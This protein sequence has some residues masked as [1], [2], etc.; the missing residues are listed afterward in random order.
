MNKKFLTIILIFCFTF[1]FLYANTPNAI[2]S[3]NN[4]YGG[5]DYIEKNNNES[6]DEKWG[7]NFVYNRIGVKEKDKGTFFEIITPVENMFKFVMAEIM[8]LFPTTGFVFKQDYN[9]YTDPMDVENYN[10]SH[11]N[12]FLYSSNEYEKY[13]DVN[14]TNH[15]AVIGFKVLL[16]LVFLAVCFYCAFCYIRGLINSK[17]G[18]QVSMLPVI[19]IRVLVCIFAFLLLPFLPP[20]LLKAS[21]YLGFLI[22]GI[23]F[24]ERMLFEICINWAGFSAIIVFLV[25]IGAGSIV[26][27]NVGGIGFLFTSLGN[28]A[29]P[30]FACFGTTFILGLTQLINIYVWEIELFIANV[31]LIF[32]LPFTLFNL[33]KNH[34]SFLGIKISSIVKFFIFNFIEICVAVVV[35]SLLYKLTKNGWNYEF[36]QNFILSLF[37]YLIPCLMLSTLMPVI[38]KVIDSMLKGSLSDTNSV[39]TSTIKQILGAGYVSGVLGSKDGQKALSSGFTNSVNA[40]GK[41]GAGAI[42]KG[43]SFDQR[44]SNFGKGFKEGWGGAKQQGLKN[45]AKNQLQKENYLKNMRNLKQN[46]GS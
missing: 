29:L 26:S 3:D 34:S 22:T 15:N 12:P 37:K 8:N 33:D 21:K 14:R 16:P 24:K 30:I 5:V 20:L 13:D 38:S 32:L 46:N 44:L 4:N 40:L 27:A 36:G 23:E 1:T 6:E 10:I 42:G 17:E 45:D 39:S 9:S 2:P 25:G 18:F 28:Y 35:V 31:A 41:G 7:K 19:L 43:L 11:D